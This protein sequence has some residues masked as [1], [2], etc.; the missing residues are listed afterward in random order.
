MCLNRGLKWW[1]VRFAIY[2]GLEGEYRL[3][4][5]ED[6][7]ATGAFCSGL[8]GFLQLASVYCR[9]EWRLKGAGLRKWWRC[10]LFSWDYARG[11]GGRGFSEGWWWMLF[12]LLF[13]WTFCLFFT[14]RSP[15]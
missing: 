13:L 10:F 11:Y 4:G 9:D 8:D 6:G 1:R 2:A 15:L 12:S 14:R 5:G 3:S 7:R